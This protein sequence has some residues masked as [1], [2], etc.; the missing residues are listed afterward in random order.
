METSQVILSHQPGGRSTILDA[1]GKEE[2]INGSADL[3][4]GDT[5]R[6]DDKQSLLTFPGG[7][8]VRLDTGTRLKFVSESESGSAISL[9]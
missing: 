9:E 4:P 8:A 3:T 6:T 7:G 1:E 2:T 5:L